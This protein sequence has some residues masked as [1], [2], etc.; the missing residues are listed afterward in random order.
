MPAAVANILLVVGL[1]AIWLAFAPLK[2][3]GQVST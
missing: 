2:L 1:A 3:G